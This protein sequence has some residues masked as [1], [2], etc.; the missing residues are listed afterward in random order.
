MLSTAQLRIGIHSGQVIAGIVGTSKPKYCLFGNNV[1]IAN[2]L[3]SLS[4][5]GRVLISGVTK[6]YIN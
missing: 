3:E 6:R 1:T 5:K 4:Q 2:R